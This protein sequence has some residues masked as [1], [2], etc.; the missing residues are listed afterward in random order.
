MM[1]T[2]SLAVGTGDRSGTYSHA[3]L[4]TN[5]VTDHR[6]GLILQKLDCVSWKID[7]TNMLLIFYDHRKIKGTK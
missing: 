1:Q 4:P 3:Q 2:V 6:I 7:E 5:R